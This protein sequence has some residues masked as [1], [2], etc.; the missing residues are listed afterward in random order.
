MLRELACYDPKNQVTFHNQFFFFKKNSICS[1]Y[2][3]INNQ[4]LFSIV[5]QIM[6]HPVYSNIRCTD[7]ALECY[8]VRGG[9]RVN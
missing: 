8:N 9:A 7:S 1:I 3:F 6:N 5:L 4:P 2:F